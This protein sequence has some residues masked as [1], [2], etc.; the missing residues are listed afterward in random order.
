MPIIEQAGNILTPFGGAVTGLS[1]D[2][3]HVTV[4]QVRSTSASGNY[5]IK[6]PGMSQARQYFVDTENTN[7]PAGTKW[8]RIL[9]PSK[10]NYTL[11]ET[12]LDSWSNSDT[13]ALIDNF[14]YFMYAFVNPSTNVR[15]QSW[16]FSK[17]GDTNFRNLPPTNHGGT[18]SP[19][20]TLIN[21]TRMADGTSYS[22]YLRTG[23]SSFGGICDDG[24]S[25]EWGQICLKS[26]GPGT[27]SGSGGGFSDFP[28]YHS[29]AIQQTSPG[30][31]G[32]GDTDCSNSDGGYN[33]TKCTSTRN[34]A[35]YVG[36]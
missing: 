33:V 24:R 26:S 23:I 17:P 21:T 35:V 29:F 16:Y 34:F 36:G 31:N 1:A 27:V 12:E 20:I 14:N 28:G 25:G 5:W 2:S 9:L 7:G 4:A 3:P 8:V 19:L 15:T 18:G 6:L 13:P 22:K 32:Y 11:Q 10:L 30:Q